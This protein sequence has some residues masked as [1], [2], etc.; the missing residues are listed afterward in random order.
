MWFHPDVS[1]FS[2]FSV[3]GGVPRLGW[4]WAVP[5]PHL[6]SA[7][8]VCGVDRAVECVARN[9]QVRRIHKPTLAHGHAADDT[10][11]QNL[12]DICPRAHFFSRPLR[13]SH[14]CSRDKGLL[15]EILS[16]EGGWNGFLGEGV[17]CRFCGE[18]DGNG[19]LFWCC[20]NLPLVQIRENLEFH[21]FGTKGQEQLA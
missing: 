15:R 5:A 16:G 20:S 2:I 6:Q 10:V 13:C 8:V 1:A 9:H 19:H 3:F 11:Q 12:P 4:W 17:P 18:A 14:V 7:G 21:D